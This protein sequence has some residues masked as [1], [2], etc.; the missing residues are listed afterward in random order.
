[1]ASDHQSDPIFTDASPG[2]SKRKAVILEAES[3]DNGSEM[4]SVGNRVSDQSTAFYGP[5]G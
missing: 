5:Q 1:M 4:V 3:Y 2:E